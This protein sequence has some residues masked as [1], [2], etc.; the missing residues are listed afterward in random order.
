[1]SDR[2]DMEIETGLAELTAAYRKAAPQPGAAL[3]ARVLEDAAAAQADAA[4]VDAA[5]AELSEAV[6][7]GAPRPSEALVARVLDTAREV[8]GT[9][10][11]DA[12]DV[13]LAELGEAVRA[14]T[15]RP[16]ADLVARVLADA[17][18]VTAE[19]RP[20][21][22]QREVRRTLISWR[23]WLG[24]PAGGTQIGGNGIALLGWGA[25]ATAA[26]VLAIVIG[27]G[28]GMQMQDDFS[29]TEANDADEQIFL[30]SESGLLPDEFL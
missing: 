21:A 29:L 9:A 7:A 10:E 24:L 12:V 23:S 11:A 6:A 14:G 22:A 25:G 18:T 26:A 8:S 20:A 5:L 16:G 15:P 27:M 1:M 13:A 17:A 3:V 19:H 28:V 30:L 2:P 4:C